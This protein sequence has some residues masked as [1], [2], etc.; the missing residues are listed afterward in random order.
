[1]RDDDIEQDQVVMIGK[2]QLFTRD[3]IYNYLG[4][5]TTLF[6]ALLKEGCY[7]GF[8]FNNKNF[9]H[10]MNTLIAFKNSLFLLMDKLRFFY[11]Y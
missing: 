10:G 2:R 9:Y 11:N 8:V 5:V 6:E 7:F 4:Q 1:M 3:A